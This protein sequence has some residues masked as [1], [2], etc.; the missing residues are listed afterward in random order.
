MPWTTCSSRRSSAR[1]LRRV[2]FDTL[3][4][5]LDSE[6][7]AAALNMAID[8]ALLRAASAPTLRVYRWARP[9]VSF[10]YFGKWADAARARPEWEIVRRWTGGGIVPHG[11]DVTYSLVV[12]RVHP[13]FAVGPAESYRLI[14]E[15]V[16]AVLGNA[17]LASTVPPQI[18]AACF[19]SPVLHDVLMADR[20]VAGAAQRRSKLGLLHQGSIQ[21]AEFDSSA[22]S[23]AFSPSVFRL[24]LGDGVMRES[25]HL[26]REKYAANE[27]TRR[28]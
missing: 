28:C 17:L 19:E 1:C 8:E 4:E 20:K 5:V 26:A 6:P 14:H 25:A 15:C 22:L 9:A 3:I 10:G 16:A 7:H 23:A 12:P 27:W 2:L 18:S 11:E 24:P 13:F 21:C